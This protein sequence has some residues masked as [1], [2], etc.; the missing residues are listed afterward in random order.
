MDLSIIVPTRN[1][2]QLLKKM[3]ASLLR[4]SHPLTGVEIIVVD[5]GSTDDTSDV[6]KSFSN[7]VDNFIYVCEEDPG[8]HKARHAGCSAA[9][10][11]FL[12]Y[13]DDDVTVAPSWLNA[14]L[15]SLSDK[16]VGLVGGMIL[17]DFETPPPDWVDEL[18]EHTELGWHLIAY[19]LLDLGFQ[20]K[21]V[22]PELV[23]GCNYTVKKSDLLAHGGFHPDSV[24]KDMISYRGDGETA[25]SRK[26]TDSGKRAVYRPYARVDHWVAKERMMPEFIRNRYFAEGIS[27]SFSHIRKSGGRLANPSDYPGSSIPSDLSGILQLSH[28]ALK[29]G[30]EFHQNQAGNDPELMRWILRENYLS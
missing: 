13:L 30:Y 26:I 20:P 5:N 14:I 17:P 2:E 24:P 15:E 29:D 6:C 22:P 19:S 7:E 8:L 9:T 23:F 21:D 16:D 27:L 12:A 4:Q 10:G 18:I 28:Q 11:E 25:L 3:L 1:R